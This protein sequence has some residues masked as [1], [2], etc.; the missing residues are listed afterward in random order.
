MGIS[1]TLAFHLRSLLRVMR[2]G[3]GGTEA[4]LTVLN[5]PDDMVTVSNRLLDC[6]LDNGGLL[7]VEHIVLLVNNS[8]TPWLSKLHICRVY[9]KLIACFNADGQI[10]Q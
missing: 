7:S 5:R 8:D 1:E 10:S 9:L 2:W 6:L 3:G 4:K